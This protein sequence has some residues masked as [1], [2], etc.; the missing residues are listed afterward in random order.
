MKSTFMRII[1]CEKFDLTEL[2]GRI[3]YYHAHGELTDADREEWIGLARE[4]AQEVLEVDAKTEILALWE[5]INAIRE[6]LTALTGSSGAGLGVDEYP[7]FVQPT[8]AHDAYKPGD[9]ITF[10]GKHYRCLISNCVWSPE[11][12]PAGWEEVQ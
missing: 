6:Q 8:G 7:E 3:N 1:A 12:Y 11:V 2:I 5:A 10:N 4:K 9:M